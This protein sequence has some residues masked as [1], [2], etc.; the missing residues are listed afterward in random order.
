MAV[1]TEVMMGP[2]PAAA[3]RSGPVRLIRGYG[4]EG[5]RWDAGDL[6]EILGICVARRAGNG[7]GNWRGLFSPQ[8]EI[9]R[10]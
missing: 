4:W 9:G 8:P 5:M 1:P 6:S 2:S 3:D 7:F 10:S